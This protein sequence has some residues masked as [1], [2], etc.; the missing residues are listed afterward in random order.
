MFQP[1][2]GT[3]ESEGAPTLPLDWSSEPSAPNR[4]GEVIT[5][6]WHALPL[7]SFLLLASSPGASAAQSTQETEGWGLDLTIDGFGLVIGNIPRV[8]GLRLN[9]RDSYLEQVNGLNLTIWKP[10]DEVGGNINGVAIGLVAPNADRIHGI[11]AGLLATLA[12]ER[13][14]GIAIGGLAVVSQGSLQGL[15]M[16]GLAT[17]AQDR[18]AGV[19]LGGLAV[20]SEGD[21]EGL[22][23]GGL[24]TVS[25]RNV[26]G[27]SVGGLANVAEGSVDGVSVGGLAT[28]AQGSVRGLSVGGLATVAEGDIDG[29]SVGGLASVAQGAIRGIHAGGLAVVGEGDVTGVSL[30]GLAVVSGAGSLRG[31]ASA[32]GAVVA[33]DRISGFAAAGYKVDA[34][35]MSGISLAL[36]WLDVHDLTGFSVAGYNQVRGAQVGLS[37][38]IYNSADELSGVQIGLLNRAGNNPPGLRY[39]PFFNAHFD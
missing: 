31:I 23:V 11:S 21:V 22:S 2:V 37:I 1:T 26:R 30:G 18:V 4:E 33:N 14:A 20:V 16:G 38:G 5:R 25:Q 8:N 27:I 12:D 34:F 17:V 24:A 36:G 15:S 35:E 28:V 39:L 7:I 9:F 13:M 3:E 29:L 6:R 19:T 32:L 10:R